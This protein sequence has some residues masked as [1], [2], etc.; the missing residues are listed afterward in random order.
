VINRQF[1]AEWQDTRGDSQTGTRPRLGWRRWAAQIAYGYVA[2][3]TTLIARNRSACSALLLVLI[4]LT[5][6][7]STVRQTRPTYSEPSTV[8]AN[9]IFHKGELAP[10]IELQ[11]LADA[12]TAPALLR[13]SWLELLLKQPQ[14]ALD[15]SAQVLYA[16]HKPSA[17]DESF[18][19]YVR[20]E[21]F[22]VQGNKKRG[23]FDRKRARELALDPELQRRLLPAVLPTPSRGPAWGRVAVEPRA[24]WRPLP[25]N[26][27]NLDR[28]Q[29][30]RRVTIH[31]SAMYFRDTRPRAAAAQIGRIQREHM[32]NRE[33]GDIGYHF[34]ID[35]SGRVWE[36][37]E[38][39]YQGAHASGS[40]NVGNIGIC[41]LGNFVRQNKDGQGPTSAQVQ[42]MEQLVMQMMRHYRFGGDALFCHSDFKNTA[43]PGPRMQ[44]IVKQFAKQLQAR[45]AGRGRSAVGAG[46]TGAEEEEDE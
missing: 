46:V 24:S 5:S 6:C 40:N 36:G 37:R 18:A 31:H 38:L 2:E 21:A 44:P 45:L 41:L 28:M 22:R 9:S 16:A 11:H 10:D 13:R 1:R 39:R 27:S 4:T 26:R 23:D 32:Q 25:A 42:S 3:R 30:P 29:R 35:P 17:N 7:M 20:A 8:S 15:T 12:R 43:C 33:Y 14:A 34:L 19:R